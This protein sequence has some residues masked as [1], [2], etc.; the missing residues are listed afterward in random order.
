MQH[1]RNGWDGL[2]QEGRPS[3]KPYAGGFN[4]A[5]VLC[6][7]LFAK[8]NHRLDRISASAPINKP[9]HSE[10][11]ISCSTVSCAAALIDSFRL[12]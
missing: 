4:R 8:R 9:S 7:Q 6:S 3:R 11:S 5:F 12:G 1:A 2:L 10:S